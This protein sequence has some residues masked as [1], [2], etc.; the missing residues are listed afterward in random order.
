MTLSP[1]LQRAVREEA[2]PSH[3]RSLAIAEGM[4]TLMDDGIRKIAAGET[5]VA[6]LLRTVGTISNS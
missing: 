6:E 3:L 4:K 1:G 2:D 5:S